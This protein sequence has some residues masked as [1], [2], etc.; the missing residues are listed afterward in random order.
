MD[1]V[2]FE[3]VPSRQSHSQS[4]AQSPVEGSRM[5]K[6]PKPAPRSASLDVG[7]GGPL[8]PASDT[9][10]PTSMPSEMDPEYAKRQQDISNGID[11]DIRSKAAE[12]IEIGRDERRLTLTSIPFDPFLECLYCNQRFRYGEIQ[13]YRKHVNECSGGTTD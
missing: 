10:Q 4:S 5:L 8:L 13:K 6:A 9:Q 1:Y 11:D 2:N 7:K 12:V 3:V